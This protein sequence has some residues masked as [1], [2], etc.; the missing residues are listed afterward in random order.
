[1]LPSLTTERL[2]V[3][4]LRVEDASDLHAAY[5]DADEH[6]HDD[7]TPQEPPPPSHDR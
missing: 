4:P 6:H 2:W 5:S 7:R 1:M 3:R